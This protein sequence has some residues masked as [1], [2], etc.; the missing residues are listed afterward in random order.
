[1]QKVIISYTSC[2]ILLDNIDELDLLHKL[3]GAIV[4]TNEVKLEF[5]KELPIWIE[6]KEAEDKNYQSI[7][8]NTVD[9]GEASTIALAIENDDCLLII[10]D[11][12]GR[13]FAQQ[14][15]L[16]IIGTM[17]VIV[18]AKLSGIISSIKPLIHKI[19]NTNFRV[20]QEIEKIMLAKAGE[21]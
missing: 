19:R 16:H 7:I 10:D 21:V 4:T 8:E 11:L 12:K 3:Y 13:K 5:G 6:I 1:M 15:G 18:D 2:L 17:G 20:T 14:L 9:K